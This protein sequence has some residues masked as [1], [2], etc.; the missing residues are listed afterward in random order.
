MFCTIVFDGENIVHDI[1]SGQVIKKT[2][3]IMAC[4]LRFRL[5]EFP[6]MC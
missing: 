2:V 3:A 5:G 6:S 4:W 1:I